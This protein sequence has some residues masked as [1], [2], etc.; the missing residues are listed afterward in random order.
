[1]KLG[2]IFACDEDGGIGK[3]GK[4]PW[5]FPADLQQFKDATMGCPI[6]MGRLTWE[7]FDG[8]VLPGRPHIVITSSVKVGDCAKVD[9]EDVWMVPDLDTAKYLAER[10]IE[11]RELQSEWAWVIGGARLILDAQLAASKIR[12]TH[13]RGHYD[14]DVKVHPNFFIHMMVNRLQFTEIM[15]TDDFKVTE[16]LM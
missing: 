8:R 9:G 10:F 13:I 4:L 6:I 16:Y 1:M 7:S 15:E 14:C 12:V 2:I 5:H 3:D 11:T